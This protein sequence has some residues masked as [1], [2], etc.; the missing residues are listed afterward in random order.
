MED[1]TIFL[2]QTEMMKLVL[3]LEVEVGLMF[4]SFYFFVSLFVHIKFQ[5]L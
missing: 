2:F 4:F 1:E 5:V 3:K